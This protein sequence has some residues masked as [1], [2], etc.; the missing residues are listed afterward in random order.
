MYNITYDVDS[1]EI[2]FAFHT[3][4]STTKYFTIIIAPRAIY[5]MQ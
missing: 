2:C 3:E 5:I 4:K 1:E